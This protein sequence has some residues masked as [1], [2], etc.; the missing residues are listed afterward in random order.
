MM[1][2]L[3]YTILLDVITIEVWNSLGEEVTDVE[4]DSMQHFCISACMHACMHAGENGNGVNVLCACT[5]Y[6][7][8][9]RIV[10][11]IEG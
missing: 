4:W 8:T 6:R 7:E 5:I 10:G 9:F 2:S 3:I 1:Y 11:I